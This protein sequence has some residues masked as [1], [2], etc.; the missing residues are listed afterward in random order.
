MK[1]RFGH[2]SLRE[3]LLQNKRA[4]DFLADSAGKPRMAE[5]SLM[6]PEPK[7]RAPAGSSGQPLEADTIRAVGQLLARHPRVLFAVRQNGGAM[8]DSEGRTSIW[9]YKIVRASSRMVLPDFWG[10]LDGG[11]PFALE[12]KRPGW[13]FRGFDEHA[14]RQRAFLMLVQLM[15]G[16]SGFCCDATEANEIVNGSPADLTKGA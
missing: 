2:V 16:R 8:T 4:L 12:C 7:K 15:G 1:R 6:P 11:V 3:R 13:K 5:S 9:F 10:F 14:K